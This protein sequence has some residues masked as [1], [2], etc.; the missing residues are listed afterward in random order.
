MFNITKKLKFQRGQNNFG[1]ELIK[2]LVVPTFVIDKTGV[3][4]V[5]NDACAELTGV[6]ASEVVGTKDHWRG[7]YREARPCLVDLVLNATKGITAAYANIQIDQDGTG[8]AENWCDLP[9]GVRRYLA[10]DAKV[11]RGKNGEIFA[12]VE[13]VRDFTEK[14]LAQMSAAEA[15]A[16]RTAAAEQ[17]RGVI[18]RIADGL[19]SLAKGR[20]D[21]NFTEF[22]PEDYKR[23]RM[24]FNQAI[25][26][27]N[28]A[29]V[30]IRGASESVARSADE[31]AG[32]A[33]AL[34]E[35]AEHQAAMLEETAAAHDQITATVNRTRELS[36]ET[37]SAVAKTRDNALASREV[38]NDTVLAIESIKT[39]SSS[40]AQIIGV[41]DEIAFQTNL[42]A[43]NAGVEAARA[44]DAGRG[45][46]VVA[47]EVRA[48][49][50]RSAGAAKEIKEL[51]ESAS[52]AVGRG[53]DL[54][55]QTGQN[56]HRIVDEVADVANRVQE[57]A[58][59]AD[60]QSVA[61]TEV[62]RAIGELDIVT[63]KNASVANETAQGCS[64][65]T[66]QALLLA[67]SVARFS[68][69][70]NESAGT[71]D[72]DKAAAAHLEWKVKLIR[73]A[74]TAET[75]DVAT[76]SAD[77]CCPLGK[78]LHGDAKRQYGAKRTLSVLTRAHAQFHCEAGKVADTI[79]RKDMRRARAM[80][81]SGTPFA[82]AS[83]EVGVA[84]QNLKHDQARAA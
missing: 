30:E 79:N 35:R 42:L 20:L 75:L 62:N 49:A 76:I 70:A 21:W 12:A 6:P 27:L 82:R 55:N 31:I 2:Q 1:L 50:Q 36:R 77:N 10:I 45:F 38:V 32:G 51:I 16:A 53:V 56:L 37:A 33:A 5:W 11:I 39:S 84:L 7:F 29:M 15:D 23:I 4:L 67:T 54:V 64:D 66:E 68:T 81:E 52:R 72:L 19:K 59:S 58:T 8:R 48:L 61:L 26:E 13:T 14:H 22:F 57:I 83:Q 24:D 63:Q 71:I 34:P 40:I 18:D 28:A 17:L 69:Q 47:S 78:W 3:I 41:I 60:E 46:A 43:L 9:K 74:E 73:A 44:G 65:L 80:M 25:A